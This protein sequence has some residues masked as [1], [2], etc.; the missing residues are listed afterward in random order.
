MTN[1][2][3]LEATKKP[4]QNKYDLGYK[5]GI[6]KKKG[7]LAKAFNDGEKYALSRPTQDV[8]DLIEK[9]TKQFPSLRANNPT[10]PCMY[11]PSIIITWLRKHWQPKVR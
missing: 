3:P 11:S 2:E 5:K 8:E 4:L 9:F 6:Y 7:E 1:P 10:L